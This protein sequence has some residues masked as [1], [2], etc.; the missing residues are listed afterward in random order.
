MART[1]LNEKLIKEISAVIA[2][3]NYAVVACE[4]VGIN[5]STYYDWLNRG[6]REPG[7]IYED[8]SNAIKKARAQAEVRNV[9]LLRNHA[10]ESWQASAWWLERTQP[11]RWGKR[12]RKD[13]ANDEALEKLDDILGAISKKAAEDD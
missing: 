10:K 5:P 12:E 6:E 8:F 4:Y 7:S 13:N 3:G 2:D 9:D 1:L 11:N